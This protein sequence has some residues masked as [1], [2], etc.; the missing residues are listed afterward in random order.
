MEFMLIIF[1]CMV[2]AFAGGFFIGE[3]VCM[4]TFAEY[5]EKRQRAFEKKMM[6]IMRG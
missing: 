3:Q 6:K 2:V 4:N 5:F 1:L